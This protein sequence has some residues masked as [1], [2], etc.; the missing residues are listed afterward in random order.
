MSVSFLGVFS[1]KLIFYL[2]DGPLFS[3][4]DG[5]N[6]SCSEALMNDMTLMSNLYVDPK[7]FKMCNGWGDAGTKQTHVVEYLSYYAPIVT[8]RGR[9]F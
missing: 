3:R 9:F 6:K 1:W 7:E 4:M 2:G 5:W 8:I